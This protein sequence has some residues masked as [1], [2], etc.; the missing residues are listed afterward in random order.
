MTYMR[1]IEVRFLEGLFEGNAPGYVLDFTNRTFADFFASEVGINIYDD[2][3]ANAGTS[4]GKRLRTFLQRGQKPAIVKA[5]TALWDYRQDYIVREGLTEPISDARQRLS[6]IVERLGGQ[7][8]RQV[9]P[10][11]VTAAKTMDPDTFAR[12]QRDFSAIHPLEPQPRGYAFERFFKDLFDSAGLSARGA[13]RLTGEQIDGS[14]QLDGETYLLEARWQ[15][16]PSDAAQLR[17]FQGKV[18]DRPAWAR[19]LFVSYSGFSEQ[20]LLAFGAKQ[21]VLMD[22][23]DIHEALT[24]RISIAAVLSEKVR[25]AVEFKKAFVRVWDLYPEN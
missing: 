13:F 22:G 10:P 25:R 19:G 5:L 17:A 11:V 21:I 23:L 2:A 1:A 8:L 7:P 14:F 3:Y 4:K 9:Q 16:A 12:L 20:G 15:Q 24:R 18:A 6:A